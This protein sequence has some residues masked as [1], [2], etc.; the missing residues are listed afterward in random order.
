MDNC[1][2]TKTVRFKFI[3][4]VNK[5]KLF[6]ITNLTNKTDIIKTSVLIMQLK[7]TIL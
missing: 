3:E 1:E 5:I 4:K 2:A 6:N 7:P